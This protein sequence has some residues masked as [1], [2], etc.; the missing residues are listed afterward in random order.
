MKLY[1]VKHAVKLCVAGLLLSATSCSEPEVETPNILLIMADDVGYSD[2]SAYGGEIQTPNIE[3]L[4]NNG[5]RFTT[6]YNMAKSSNT[7][8]I[9]N[10]NHN[11]KSGSGIKTIKF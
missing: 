11:K 7:V 2:I 5:M 3:R 10:R 6:F 4:A 8:L 9:D 1:Q